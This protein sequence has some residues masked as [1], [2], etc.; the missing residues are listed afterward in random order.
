MLQLLDLPLQVVLPLLGLLEKLSS[1][2]Q[3][4][5]LIPEEVVDHFQLVDAG[6]EAIIRLDKAVIRLGR[7]EV[8]VVLG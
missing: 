2:M 8:P 3:L 7:L 4:S 5:D 6:L 1:H